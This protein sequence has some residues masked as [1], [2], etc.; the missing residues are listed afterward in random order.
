MLGCALLEGVEVNEG[1]R[2]YAHPPIVEAGLTVSLDPAQT[3]D[4]AFVAA[5][6]DELFK[7]W[8]SEN[9][10][11]LEGTLVPLSG[12]SDSPLSGDH[13]LVGF[14]RKLGSER[15]RLI[16][17][18]VLYVRAYR[19]DS[20][21]HWDDFIVSAMKYLIPLVEGTSANVVNALEVRFVNELPI[22]LDAA[23]YE[24]GDY[25]RMYVDV[26]GRLPQGVNRMFAQVDIPFE[27]DGEVV[28]TQT[29]VFA[30]DRASRPVLVLDLEVGKSIPPSGVNDLGASLRVLRSVKNEIFEGAITDACRIQMRGGMQ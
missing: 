29:T 20:Y 12:T 7:G 2:L 26:P 5:R 27:R 22:P 13:Q 18:E 4:V 11:N 10:F 15:F 17:N 21:T 9:V 3:V 8:E 6:F 14:Q 25:V 1:D 19:G 16:D 24:I 23:S 30:G 28:H